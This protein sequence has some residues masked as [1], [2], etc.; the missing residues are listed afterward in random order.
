MNK[1]EKIHNTLLNKLEKGEYV[2][3]IKA[4]RAKCLECC[5]FQSSQVSNC[6]IDDCILHQFR[7]GKNPWGKSPLNPKKRVA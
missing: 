4:I 6:H 5:N 3:P 1:Y 2:S 7:I